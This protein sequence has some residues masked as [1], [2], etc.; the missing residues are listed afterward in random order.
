MK[1]GIKFCVQICQI[2]E[3]RI[4]H[5]KTKIELFNLERQMAKMTFDRQVGLY[6]F[7]LD[8]YEILL[9]NIPES[10]QQEIL[11]LYNELK[12]MKKNH[13]IRIYK[14]LREKYQ[15]LKESL[16]DYP[17]SINIDL[18][19]ELKDIEL[20]NIY[21]Y[22]EDKD[23]SIYKHI[24]L[25][26]NIT[27]ELSKKRNIIIYP[28]YPLQSNREYRHFYNKISYKYLEELSKDYSFNIERKNLN[29]IKVKKM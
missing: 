21:V 5:E 3:R 19:N 28:E 25:Y 9:N 13:N 11:K 6:A 17:R 27:S 26:N 14:S 29:K 20:P 23:V 1:Y 10:S 2:E 12:E 22:Q 24:I 15:L 4:K 8:K 7:K 16:S 18:R